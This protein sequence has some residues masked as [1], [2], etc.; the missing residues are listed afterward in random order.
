MACLLFKLCKGKRFVYLLSIFIVKFHLMSASELVQTLRSSEKLIYSGLVMKGAY[1]YAP[2][3]S[4]SIIHPGAISQTNGY[5]SLSVHTEMFYKNH[6]SRLIVANHRSNTSVRGGTW[7]ANSEP[8]S[9]FSNRQSVFQ[10][11][12]CSAKPF[13]L[14]ERSSSPHWQHPVPKVIIDNC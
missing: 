4:W 2:L 8:C 10:T 7:L 13:F 5:R 3:N 11:I 14:L 12:Q 9:N 6:L 1:I